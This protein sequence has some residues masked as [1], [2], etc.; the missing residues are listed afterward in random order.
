M[1]LVRIGR[2]RR[3]HGLRGEL[4]L[5]GASLTPAELQAVGSFTWRGRDGASRRLVLEE[6]RGGPERLLVRFQGFEDRDQAARLGAGELLA[7]RSRIPDPGPG[8]AYTFQLVGLRVVEED[9]RELGV[10]TD[11]L[12]SGAHPIYVVRGPRELLIPAVEP[13]VRRVDLEAGVMVVALPRGLE[14]L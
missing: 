5:E 7:E 8:V 10:L 11:V 6:V 1:D 14:E 9:G 12:R 2:L 4:V 3:P 13:V